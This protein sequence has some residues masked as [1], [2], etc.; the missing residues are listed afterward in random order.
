M[1]WVR[2]D[3]GAATHPKILRAGPVAAWIWQAALCY[4]NRHATNGLIPRASLRAVYPSDELSTR[5]LNLAAARLVEV[6]L[7]ELDPDGWRIHDYEDYQREAMREHIASRRESDRERQR[8]HREQV[9]LATS[10]RSVRAELETSSRPVGDQLAASSRRVGDEL[11]TS[12]PTVGD[13]LA[14]DG[15]LKTS[16]IRSMSQRDSRAPARAPV[17]PSRPVPSRP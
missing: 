17:L 8:R 10:S 7:W 11:A 4:A 12:S 16:K 14:Q 3:D 2:I 1:T 6:G 13:E 5:A 9:D 15:P